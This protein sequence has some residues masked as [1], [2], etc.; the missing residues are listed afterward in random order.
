VHGQDAGFDRCCPPRE[1]GERVS[2]KGV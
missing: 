2:A 1:V